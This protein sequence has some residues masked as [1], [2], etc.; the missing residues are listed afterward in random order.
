MHTCLHGGLLFGETMEVSEAPFDFAFDGCEIACS[1]LTCARCGS[2]VLSR[3]GVAFHAG[4]VMSEA[5]DLYRTLARGPAPSSD[6]AG[7][8]A[9]RGARLWGCACG[10]LW[11][12]DD[13][14]APAGLR[15]EREAPLPAG[16][17]CP[18]HPAFVGA[19]LDGEPVAAGDAAGLAAL[20]AGSILG[21]SARA[22]P[23]H[24][25]HYPA[26]WALRLASVSPGP[27]RLEVLEAGL[28]CA[29]SVDREL[30][31][32]GLDLWR[33]RPVEARQLV[34]GR[35][36]RDLDEVHLT[37]EAPGDDDVSGPPQRTS[38]ASLFREALSLQLQLEADADDAGAR[39]GRLVA[40]AIPSAL[41]SHDPRLIAA[42]TQSDLEALLA[43]L[44]SLVEPR[45]RVGVLG[46]LV[47][48]A[49]RRPAG[50]GDLF[51]RLASLGVAGRKLDA[52]RAQ[53]HV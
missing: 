7:L 44:P 40:L 23:P 13:G 52:L 43:I 20:V 50:A 33:R 46:A 9:T 24:T 37:E 35:R 17:H 19:S 5:A 38:C 39:L 1:R 8:V 10:T 47:L 34:M 41:A 30:A 25:R 2:P 4:V 32:G 27:L 21:S 28:G 18:G 15:E 29:H 22:R 3:G 48:G 42:L 51:A 26:Q 49:A 16:W 36:L 11:R 6:S 45:P 14:R 31:S 12:M 53:Y